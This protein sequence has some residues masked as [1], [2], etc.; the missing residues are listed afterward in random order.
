MVLIP[1]S[2]SIVDRIQSA[3]LGVGVGALG[4][5]MAATATT[6]AFL[7]AGIAFAIFATLGVLFALTR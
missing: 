4:V 1:I 5:H 7:V 3:A 6:T 2:N